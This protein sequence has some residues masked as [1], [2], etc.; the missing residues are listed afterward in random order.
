M[1]WKDDYRRKLT[2]AEKAVELVSSGDRIYIH[3]GCAEPDILVHAL[4]N[5]YESLKDVEL[6]HLMALGRADYVEPKYHGHFRHNALFIGGNVRSAVQRGDAD[7][8]PI[9]LGEIEALFERGEMPLDVVF[10]QV[11]PPDERGYMSLGVSVDCTLTAIRNAHMVIAEVNDQ[12]P[13][14]LGDTFVHMRRVSA[15]VES[16]HPLLE[17]PPVPF[18]DLQRKIAENVAS[19]IPDGATLQTGIGGIP[20]AVLANLGNHKNLGVHTEM[21]SDGVIPLIESGV[22]NGESKTLLK[23]KVVLSFVL[24]TQKL[25]RFVHDNPAF[26]FRTIQFTNDPFQIARNEKMMAINSALQIDLTGQVC[27]DSIGNKP[28]SGFGGQVDFIR[29]SA[30]SKGGRPIIALPATAKNGEISRIVPMLDPG[31]GVV[32]SRG[33]VHY[34]VTEFGIAYLHGKNIRQRVEALISVADPKFRDQLYEFAYKANYL[35]P[36]LVPAA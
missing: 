22:I 20:D 31:A 27:S 17:L 21:V 30:R 4:L 36:K 14:T 33:D 5:R 6:I 3:P 32:T 16:S 2:T 1:T 18:T 10:I 35:R 9:F 12:M 26:E 34:V 23:G 24:G 29:G 19:L 8:T 7:Y 13:R 15:I 25:F 28:Y 11:T